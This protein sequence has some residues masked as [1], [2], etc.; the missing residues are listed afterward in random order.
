MSKAMA[1]FFVERNPFAHTLRRHLKQVI[2]IPLS[3]PQSL[4]IH[5][6]VDDLW[7]VRQMWRR[8]KLVHIGTPYERNSA[9]G[10]MGVSSPLHP[11]GCVGWPVE[12]AE[13]GF[14]CTERYETPMADCHWRLTEQRILQLARRTLRPHHASRSSKHQETPMYL[15]MMSVLPLMMPSLTRTWALLGL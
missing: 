8:D 7:P 9:T 12:P 11:V 13:C 1:L 15:S 14:F 6:V 4:S 5:T 2:F 3:P 10:M